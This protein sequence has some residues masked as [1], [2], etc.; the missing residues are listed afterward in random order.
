MGTHHAADTAQP[1]VISKGKF[2]GFP[3][4]SPVCQ[5]LTEVPALLCELPS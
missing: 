1:V 4:H 2:Q 5:L 3:K